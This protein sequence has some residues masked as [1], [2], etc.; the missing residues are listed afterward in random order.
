MRNL[1]QLRFVVANFKVLQGLRGVP[2]GLLLVFTSLW[3][4]SQQ[5]PS[6]DPTWPLIATSVAIVA[7]VALEGYYARV[8]GRV[9]PSKENRRV[10]VMLG[11]LFG[12][13]G[14]GAFVLDTGKVL[15]VSAVGM[16]FVVAVLA[17][18]ARMLWQAKVQSWVGQWLYPVTA[19]AMLLVSLLPLVA[20]NWLATI[21]F[22]SSKLAVMTSI[23]LI[24]TVAGFLIHIFL[25]RSLPAAGIANND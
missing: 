13:A 14:L 15:K 17:D 21:G 19:V 9:M 4:N 16:V 5:G 6:R 23:G 1:D 25:V 3:A 24:V 8:F 12:A 18:W 20:E 10:E 11:A 2:I 7:Y 22:V